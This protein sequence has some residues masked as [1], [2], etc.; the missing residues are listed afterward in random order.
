MKESILN[1]IIK[2]KNIFL[3]DGFGALFT[4]LLLFFVL[5][6]FNDFFGLSQNILEYLAALAL[7][8]SIYSVS[9]YFLV[10]DNWKLFL[11]IIC[12]ANILYCVLTIGLLFYHYQIISIYGI[13]YFLGEIAVIAGIVFLEIKTIKQQL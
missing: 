13:A 2:P 8:F 4:T 12:T 9:C 10:S 1:F 5:R 3:L 6:T 7:I 11:K